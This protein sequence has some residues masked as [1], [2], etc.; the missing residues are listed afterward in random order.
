M[1]QPMWLVSLLKKYF[2]YRFKIARLTR[3]P[4]IGK[5][6]DEIM[7]KEDDIIYLPKDTVIIHQSLHPENILLP[8][9]IVDLFIA[10]ASH[11]WIMNSCICREAAGCTDFPHE[12]GCVFL[13]E[14]VLKINPKL[15]RLVTKEEALA[16][17]HKCQQAGLFQ[18]IGRDKLDT[19][20]LGTGPGSKLL[21]ICNCCPCCC[22]FKMM[23]DL[24]EE[25]N[26]RVTRMPGVELKVLDTCQGCGACTEGACF[27]NAIHMG[28][29][30]KAFIKADC[31]GCGHCVEVCPTASIELHI[32]NPEFYEDT[33]KRLSAAVDVT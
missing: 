6:M 9:Q 10:K 18:M 31:R 14:A 12:F 23:P 30:G 13:G 22:L 17:V 11:R 25:I 29:D 27:V 24:N 2:P 1:S 4:V 5:W 8:S 26:A 16:H 33:I 7:F 19:L 20:W 21:T 28:E 3:V 32:E 15:G